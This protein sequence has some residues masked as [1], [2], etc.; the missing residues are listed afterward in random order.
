MR[1]FYGLVAACALL[2]TGQMFAQATGQTIL[3]N[4]N[5]SGGSVGTCSYFQGTKSASFRDTV[6]ANWT[7]LRIRIPLAVGPAPADDPRRGTVTVAIN[8]VQ[9]GDAIVVTNTSSFCG[10]WV[11]Y[12][13][14]RSLGT[15]RFS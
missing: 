12:E 8:G 3:V 9:V 1:K 4:W 15:S 7:S 2:F 5:S 10:P 14:P 13:L 11:T 6:G